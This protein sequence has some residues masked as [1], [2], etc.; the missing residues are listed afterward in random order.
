MEEGG[1]E[2]LLENS[3][4]KPRVGIRVAPEIEKLVLD[5]ALQFPTH[6]QNRTANK[7]KK[8]NSIVVSGGGVRSI[9]QRHDLT[10]KALRLKRLEKYSAE[11]NAILTESQVQALGEAKEEKQAHGEV[12][13]YHPGFLFAQDTYNVGYIKGIGKIYQQP[14][15]DTYS[16]LGF[17]KLYFQKTALTAADF[18]NDK[19]LPLFDEHGMK[20]LRM[21]TDN[22][23]EYCW[24]LEDHKY[25]LFI[26][27]S[28]IE[29]SGTKI[30]RPQTNG[31]VERLN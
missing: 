9:W 7:L 18:L 16:N 3:R 25:Q 10:T 2:G 12:G 29:H 31:F 6:G 28:A 13:T 5:Y 21:L 14:E 20:V 19:V 15:I 30:R 1:I 26:H 4:S 24:R 27:L 23:R 8:K 17:A 11:T 22:G